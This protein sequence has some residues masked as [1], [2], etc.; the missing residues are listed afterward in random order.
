M[1]KVLEK[2][3]M[4]HIATE[5]VVLIG[6][7]FYFSSKNKKLLDHIEDLS[8]R[9][10]EQEDIVQKHEKII[11]QLVQTINN[12]NNQRTG[13]YISS[14]DDKNNITKPAYR[15]QQ[16]VQPRQQHT[17]QK[18]HQ[19]HTKQSVIKQSN[20]KKISPPIKVALEEIQQ[21]KNSN[22]LIEEESDDE[23]DL[24]QEIAEELND[25]DDGNENE[26]GL[27]KRI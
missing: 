17:T 2:K 10:E 18:Q 6:I 19:T 13:S 4:I 16:S 3:D 23:S 12:Q 20:S 9:L 7:T 21:P 25:L 27:K 15:E 8:K 22:I 5:I 1:S 26:D 24:D 14:H 11:M